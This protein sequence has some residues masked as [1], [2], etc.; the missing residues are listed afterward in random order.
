MKNLTFKSLFLLLGLVAVV[1]VFTACSDDEPDTISGCT[2]STAENYN[3]EATEDDGSCVYPR[4]KFLGDYVGTLTC[5]GTLALLLNND[6]LTFTILETVG[7]GASDVTIQ[8]TGSVPVAFGGTVSGNDLTVNQ[9]LMSLPLGLDINQDGNVDEGDNL[10]MMVGGTLT[11]DTSN[12][13]MAGD[14]LITEIKF[15]ASGS[16][17]LPDDSCAVTG[18]KQ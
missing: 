4:D 12:N 2:D 1:G 5:Q 8:L 3:A 17:A 9:P 10:D 6:M 14:L 16:T 15:S 7:G 18:T 11:Y 13:T